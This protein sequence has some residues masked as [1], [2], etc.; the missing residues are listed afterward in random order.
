MKKLVAI[1]LMAI[2]LMMLSTSVLAAEETSLTVPPESETTETVGEAPGTS[3][4]TA[5]VYSIDI[6]GYTIYVM[7]EDGLVS[8]GLYRTVD[9]GEPEEIAVYTFGGILGQAVSTVAKAVTSGPEHG[10]VVSTFVRTANQERHKV[11]KQKQ[12]AR[13]AEKEEL[14]EEKQQEREARKEQ[15]MLEKE[16]KRLLKEQ[17]K[18][19]KHKG[20]QLSEDDS[21]E[22]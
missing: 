16:E 19:G 2:L 6:F 1:V 11:K 3:E 5:S 14:K 9:G 10:K 13:K 17:R 15:K 20:N 4:L 22:E 18:Q 12:E 21:T 8:V 7:E